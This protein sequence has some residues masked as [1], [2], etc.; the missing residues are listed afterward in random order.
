M[1]SPFVKPLLIVAVVGI[2]ASTATPTVAPHAPI[3]AWIEQLGDANPA[4]QVE[5]SKRLQ[6]LGEPALP[7]LLKTAQ[8]HPEP[9]VRK[10]AAEVAARIQRGEVLAIGTGANYWFNRVA[11]TPDNRHAVVTGGGLILMDLLQGKEVRR[12]LELAFARIGLA[13]TADGKQF[14]TGHQNDRVVRIGEVA[15][16]KVTQTLQG[17]T[18]GVNAV[19][20]APRADRLVSGSID[21]TLRLWDVKTGKELRRFPGIT[22]QI[23]SVDY[24]ADG[25]RILSGHTGPGSDFAVRLWDVA[26]GKEQRRLTGHRQEVST[27]L[28]MPDGKSAVSAGRD[29]AAI[30]WDLN[31]AKELRRMMHGGGI[32][33]AA[34]SPDGKRLLTAGIGD[35]TVRLWDLATGREL[36][37][38]DGHGGGALGV[39][40]SSDGGFALSCD[41][42]ATVR[43]WRLPK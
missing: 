3:A 34:L 11:F 2:L 40:F 38:F 4:R 19:A 7:H 42:R 14:A 32:Y 15:T 17:H 8:R 10:L 28:F 18:A 41:A 20:F 36:K 5:A 25:K 1:H 33:G 37:H 16:G 43:L 26:S 23:R 30:V 29:G 27:V 12:D 39:A 24:A 9:R 35:R 6:C 22:D 21:R 31:A 13:L